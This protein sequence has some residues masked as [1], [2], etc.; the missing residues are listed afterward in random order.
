MSA[1]RIVIVEDEEI[2]R[3]GTTLHLK[4]FGYDVVGNFSSG[5][6][7]IEKVADLKPDIILMDIELA[8]TMNGIEAAEII[9][10]K[11]D[12]PL[13]Y[14][15][16]HSDPETIQKA[17]SS[18]PFRYMTKPFHDTELQFTIEMAIKHHKM[19]KE[20]LITIKEYQEVFNNMPGIVYRSYLEDTKID[21]FNDNFEKI[22]GFKWGEIEHD[23]L[24]FMLPL[25]L[26]EDREILIN[27]LEESINS[28]NPFKVD[29]RIKS[30]D[31]K[32]RQLKEISKL[33]AKEEG[34]MY[35][36]GIILDINYPDQ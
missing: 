29:Y 13:I 31:G 34:Q 35:L 9:Q 5:E 18:Q 24:H 27:A 6:E 10:E 36:E 3:F 26:A 21:L 16:V 22:T 28:K 8:G 14:L 23:N 12:I 15:S 19:K 32:I 4:S 17:E 25:V 20:L 7:L 2:L 1:K 30:K 11:V 33:L